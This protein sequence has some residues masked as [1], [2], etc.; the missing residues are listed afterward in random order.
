MMTEK[1]IV[2]KGGVV[3]WGTAFFVA[4][5][6]GLVY[7]TN[8]ASWDWKLL[9]F[10]LIF[11]IGPAYVLI[12]S[13]RY[14]LLTTESIVVRSKWFSSYGRSFSFEN[15]NEVRIVIGNGVGEVLCIYKKDGTRTNWDAGHIPRFELK[16][17]RMLESHGIK[18]TSEVKLD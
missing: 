18:F 12:A 15:I 16:K 5:N 6:A 7:Y 3:N 1:D 14:F 9:I 17:I 2:I 10:C 4:F 11:E 13:S 8:D